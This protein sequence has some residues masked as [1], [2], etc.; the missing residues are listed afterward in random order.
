MF[1]LRGGTW[2]AEG[3]QGAVGG[4]TPPTERLFAFR[5]GQHHKEPLRLPYSLLLSTTRSDTSSANTY[6]LP[7]DA[8][9]DVFLW[10]VPTCHPPGEQQ[11]GDADTLGGVR[12]L[13][14]PPVCRDPLVFGVLLKQ[15]AVFIKP[16]KVSYL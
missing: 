8:L 14:R 3:N 1:V 4:G 2:S 11:P 13:R 10:S 6:S 12:C 9:W 7:P 15:I 5:A 16:W